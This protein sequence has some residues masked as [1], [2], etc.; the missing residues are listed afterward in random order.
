[1]R[2]LG[3]KKKRRDER[4]QVPT[5]AAIGIKLGGSIKSWEKRSTG[6]SSNEWMNGM[7]LA[8]ALVFSG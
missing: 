7:K 6:G 8:M 3:A 5:F 1:M 2:Y 4:V